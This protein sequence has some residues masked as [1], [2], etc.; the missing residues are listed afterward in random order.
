[1]TT[2]I[3]QVKGKETLINPEVQTLEEG[4]KILKILE[5]I[6]NDLSYK[7]NSLF[8][9]FN[10]LKNL[11]VEEPHTVDSAL[12][13]LEKYREANWQLKEKIEE[14]KKSIQKTSDFKHE[15]ISEELKNLLEKTYKM[16]L[17]LSIIE[18]HWD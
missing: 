10:Y 12:N 15:N 13:T 5:G 3:L 4:Q 16:E 8:D 1:M 2:Y 17:N 18:E 11:G 9:H 14:L 6:L 7:I